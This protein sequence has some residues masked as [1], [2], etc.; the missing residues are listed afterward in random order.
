[1]EKLLLINSFSASPLEALISVQ[2]HHV[3]EV[4]QLSPCSLQV[5]LKNGSLVSLLEELL[6]N[7][8]F[9]LSILNKIFKIYLQ[10]L[11]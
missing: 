10:N 11:K 5:S 2:I 4:K 7:K 9:H 3:P 6:L 1:M 8:M